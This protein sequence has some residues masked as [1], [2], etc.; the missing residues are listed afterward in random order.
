MIGLLLL[1][2]LSSGLSAS[3]KANNLR[4]MTLGSLPLWMQSTE[5][6]LLYRD[7]V[8]FDRPPQNTSLALDDTMVPVE[9]SMRCFTEWLAISPDSKELVI[10]KGTSPKSSIWLRTEMPSAPHSLGVLFREHGKTWDHPKV[11]LLNDDEESFPAGKIRFVNTS[12]KMII[13]HFMG[14][15]SKRFGIAPGKVSTKDVVKG[16]NLIHIAYRSSDGSARSIWK[17]NINVKANQRFQC[18]L[19]NAEPATKGKSEVALNYI[20]ELISKSLNE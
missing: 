2:V 14:V 7:K 19:Y 12:D 6:D 17:N 5:S 18:F 3:E 8:K 4:F 20:P 16:P 11:L 10:K 9:L 15:K 1:A 13:V